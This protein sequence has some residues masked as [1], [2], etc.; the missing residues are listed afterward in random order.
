MFNGATDTR[1]QKLASNLS[2]L[3]AC[4]MDSSLQRIGCFNHWLVKFSF[5]LVGM[6]LGNLSYLLVCTMDSYVLYIQSFDGD[7]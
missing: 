7:R 6:E 1:R 4:T 2:F 3:L 5:V